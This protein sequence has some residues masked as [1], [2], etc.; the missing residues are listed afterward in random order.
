MIGEEE[1]CSTHVDHWFKELVP[2]QPGMGMKQGVSNSAG[3]HS[4]LSDCVIMHVDR[5][6]T[7]AYKNIAVHITE[8]CKCLQ[9]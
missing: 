7:R 6:D 3:S 8:Y 9:E 1:P 2:C 4:N 5:H